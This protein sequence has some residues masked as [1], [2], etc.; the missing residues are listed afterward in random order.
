VVKE[1]TITELLKLGTA[2]W[3]EGASE[4]RALVAPLPSDPSRL[5]DLNRMEQVRLAKLG[6]GRAD[7]LAEAL[8]PSSLRRVLEGGLR[9]LQRVRQALAYAE[10]WDR[11]GDLPLDLALPE[12]KVRMLSCLPRPS[13]LR[14]ADGMHL[15]RLAVQGP[16]SLLGAA[17]QPTLAMIGLHRTSSA[18]GWCLAL[19]DASGAILGAWM[20]MDAPREGFIELRC[21]NHHRR[22]PLDT[23]EGLELPAPR[24]AEVVILPVPRSRS[25]PG[26]VS[27]SNFSVW[28][29]FETLQLRLGSDIPH[30]T[31]Q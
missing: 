11:R 14:R 21:G 3:F 15:D 27:G 26:L 1:S 10:K 23:W 12:N 20:V 19:E 8:V 13:V 24:A 6:E 25:I 18:V 4:R 17:P 5:V 9:A 7:A 28:S 16:G 22:V 30:L 29:P 31:V 2:S